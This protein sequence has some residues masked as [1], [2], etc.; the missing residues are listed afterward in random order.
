MD[1][2]GLD[3]L[4]LCIEVVVAVGLSDQVIL[5]VDPVHSTNDQSSVG[6]GV[7]VLAV[8][9]VQTVLHNHA[10]NGEVQLAILLDDFSLTIDQVGNKHGA[11]CLESVVTLGKAII[12]CTN[13]YS[14]THIHDALRIEVV[15]ILSNLD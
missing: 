6:L 11:V 9:L 1:K 2:A 10:V 4:T 15:V 3:Q 14:L 7:V 13:V 5:L 12:V 8:Q